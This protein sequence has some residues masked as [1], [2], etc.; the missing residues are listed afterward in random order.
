[1]RTGVRFGYTSGMARGG[2]IAA[3]LLTLAGC[4]GDDGPAGVRGT[5]ETREGPFD[6][7][8]AERSSPRPLPRPWDTPTPRTAEPR[9]DVA[10]DLTAAEE[11]DLV[12]LLRAAV[13]EPIACLPAPAREDVPSAWTLRVSARVLEDGTVESADASGASLGEPGAA[14][15]EGRVRAARF[16]APVPNA[17]LTVRS[18]WIVD[19]RPRD[20]LPPEGPA[21][22]A[23][24]PARAPEVTATEAAASTGGQPIEGPAGTTISGPTGT[25][26]ESGGGT[27]SISG[28][29]GTTISGPSGTPIGD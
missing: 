26:I 1:M 17:P 5:G 2:L 27:V 22:A 23:T 18:S 8:P 29:S 7:P 13:G 24:G 15:L 10:D 21:P 4:G 3:L 12:A 11:R 6:L 25:T 19:Q 28:P 14:C 20:T 16:P 9:I